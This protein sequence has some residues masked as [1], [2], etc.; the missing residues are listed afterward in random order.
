MRN[1]YF[2][3]LLILAFTLFAACDSQNVTRAPS[4]ESKAPSRESARKEFDKLV[5]GFEASEESIEQLM[6]SATEAQFP[7]LYEE[8]VQ[9]A[10]KVS[11]QLMQIAVK[12][13]AESA[14]FDALLWVMEHSY[15]ED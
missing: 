13:P 7:K 3:W 9:E 12:A 14:S 5:A 2:Q 6:E 8:L 1:I 15:D 11:V 4:T 10:Q